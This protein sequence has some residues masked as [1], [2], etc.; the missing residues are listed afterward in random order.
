MIVCKGIDLICSNS[1]IP[2]DSNKAVIGML[3]MPKSIVTIK[4]NKVLIK[5]NSLSFFSSKVEYLTQNILP[6]IN[7]KKKKPLIKPHHYSPTM[8]DTLKHNYKIKTI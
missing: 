5:I 6:T 8:S 4:L 7:S 2:S 3:V 1:P